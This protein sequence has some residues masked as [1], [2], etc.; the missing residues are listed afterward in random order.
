MVKGVVLWPLACCD[1]GFVSS[2]GMDV[3]RECCVLSGRGL[4][5][6]PITH[7]KESYWG[8]CVWVWSR[9]LDSGRRPTSAVEPWKQILIT[10]SFC[11]SLQIQQ[12]L[13]L[14]C[15]LHLLCI[16]SCYCQ[17]IFIACDVQTDTQEK[18]YNA[19]MYNYTRTY[20]FYSSL[21]CPHADQIFPKL[22]TVHSGLSRP[23]LE[24][25]VLNCSNWSG[26]QLLRIR[27]SN[28]GTVN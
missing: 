25:W 22:P 10:N 6:G 27:K 23:A 21:C 1:C 28:S 20:S 16:F 15:E 9:K 8:W 4:Y 3:S 7:L 18:K 2:G 11:K 12:H 13:S 5:E 26:C 19:R 24:S 17:Y 14:F